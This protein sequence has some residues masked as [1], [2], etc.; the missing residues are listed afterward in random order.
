MFTVNKQLNSLIQ[1]KFF[2]NDKELYNSNLS[3]QF[4]MIKLILSNVDKI[5]I[6]YICMYSVDK[7]KKKIILG[8]IFSSCLFTLHRLTL[9][10]YRK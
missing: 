6:N 2:Q 4:I 7:F 9:K 1:L 5:E 3:I 10:I 8:G